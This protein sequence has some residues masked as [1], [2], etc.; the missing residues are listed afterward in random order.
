M[1]EILPFSGTLYTGERLRDLKKR[2]VPKNCVL[3]SKQ[4]EFKTSSQ[5]KKM[6]MCEKIVI[7]VISYPSRAIRCTW[8]LF[9]LEPHLNDPL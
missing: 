8:K 4:T 6:K 1:D 5:S 7:N 2:K 3:Q 9:C